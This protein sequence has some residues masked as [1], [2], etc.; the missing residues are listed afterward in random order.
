[1][2]AL[3]EHGNVVTYK[4]QYACYKMKRHEADEYMSQFQQYLALN[5]YHSLSSNT[6]HPHHHHHHAGGRGG[7]GGAPGT[8]AAARGLSTDDPPSL[9]LSTS[10]SNGM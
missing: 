9:S 6:S 1:V 7:G 2:T 3:D 5:Q 10:G 4:I 8:S